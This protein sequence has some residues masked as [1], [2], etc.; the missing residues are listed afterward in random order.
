MAAPSWLARTRLEWGRMLVLRGGTGDA[1]RARAL[2]GQALAAARQLGL[3]TV[4]RRA[5]AMLD[6]HT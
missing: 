4:E 6:Q 2:L 5:A 3:G 1:D